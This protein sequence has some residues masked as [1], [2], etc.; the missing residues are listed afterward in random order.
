MPQYS[1][2]RFCIN[3]AIH[4]AYSYIN[5]VMNNY[6]SAHA[7][8]VS[9]FTTATLFSLAPI[10]SAAIIS[11]SGSTADNGG[12]GSTILI[13]NKPNFTATGDGSYDVSESG[14]SGYA[15]ISGTNCAGSVALGEVRT[16]IIT[17]DD[18][19][20]AL[21]LVNNVI[22]DNGGTAMSTDWTL[23]AIGPTPILGGGS[24][25]S[26]T[27]NDFTA[28]TYTLSESGP[29][30]YTAG[31]WSCSGDVTNLG[32]SIT[33]GIGQNASCTITNDDTP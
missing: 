33:L 21:T 4:T 3:A 29:S 31:Q 24:V 7:L 18:I 28:G 20:P 15:E 22:N 32:N 27:T 14:P 6:W 17:S 9:I 12:N 30:G 25:T 5:I 10:A 13:I 16:C 11:G 26:E 2:A 23:T 19:P 8:L 1:L